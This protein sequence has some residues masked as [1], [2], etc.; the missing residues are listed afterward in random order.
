MLP[1]PV[2]VGPV[3]Q[4]H[5]LYGAVFLVDAVDDAVVATP[6]AAQSG[7]FEAERLSPVKIR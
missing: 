2:G 1:G 5:Y 4:G 3:L 6:G 7:E